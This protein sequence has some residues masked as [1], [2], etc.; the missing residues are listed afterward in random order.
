M[1]PFIPFSLVQLLT[2]RLR[3]LLEFKPQKIQEAIDVSQNLTTLLRRIT[4]K[5]I[6]VEA[7]CEI[8]RTYLFAK[9]CDKCLDALQNVHE[10]C[11]ESTNGYHYKY[12]LRKGEDCYK[13]CLSIIG[14]QQDVY[15]PQMHQQISRWLKEITGVYS[16]GG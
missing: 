15:P 7:F 1:K 13:D 10:I 4:T 11:L 8:G 9:M 16:V 3:L 5:R 12:L 2:E 6:R 14:N